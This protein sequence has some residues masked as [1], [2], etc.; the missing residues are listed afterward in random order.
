MNGNNY[1]R[2]IISGL[3][4]DSG[5][6]IVSC[7]LT[8][9]LIKRGLNVTCFKKGPDYIDAAWL[10]AASGKPA[11]NLDSFMMGFPV[12]MKSFLK[13][14]DENGF[15]IIEGN[16]GLFDGVDVQGTHSTAELARLL[17]SPVIIIQ[18][19]SKVTRTAAA[20]ILG[21]LNMDPQIQIA[22][23]ILNRAAGERHINIVSEAIERETGISV[24][25]A[26][27]KLSDKLILPSRH[28]GLVMP[29]EINHKT[30]ILEELKN[31][32][33]EN[34]DVLKVVDI[35]ESVPAIAHNSLVEE[36]ILSS[37]VKTRERI[38]IGYFKDNSF[39]FYYPENL[40]VLEE[41]GAELI[42]IPSTNSTDPKYIEKLEKLDAL[43]IGGGFPE[44]NLPDLAAN[45]KLSSALRREVEKGLPVYAECGGLM[46]LANEVTWK[47][48][49]FTLAGILPIKI[50]MY[51]KPQ[52]H[53][54]VE[55][56]VD[57]KNPFYK[58]GTI[59]RG[60]EF[61]Y[62]RITEYS[63]AIKST[64]ALVRGRGSIDSRDGLVYRNVFASYIHIHAAANP[65]WA[66]GMI[67]SAKSYRRKKQ[68]KGLRED[69]SNG[70]SK[71]VK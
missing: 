1:P 57:R 60:H 9:S 41:A 46:Y 42:P 55:A 53:G 24:L 28:L 2:I 29:D 19:I 16:R 69:R 51:E 7:G 25:G 39:S 62:S 54:Y 30:N 58:K 50:Q 33:E 31:I 26:I 48:K 44:I 15:N 23:I 17:K 43:Y 22:G 45:N 67:E 12:I 68:T 20:S 13:Y 8:A 10:T 36:S 47:E 14:G 64:L 6:T 63:R 3:S 61:H 52:G 38:N 40:E 66:D 37:S 70:I 56:V 65:E 5:K 49:E 11:R 34:V 71:R 4:G 35:I 32:I 27:P 59:I 18:D 21:C